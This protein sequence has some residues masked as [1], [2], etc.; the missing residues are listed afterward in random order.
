M[1]QS[2]P[3][4]RNQARVAPAAID[5]PL[6]HELTTCAALHHLSGRMSESGQNPPPALQK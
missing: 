5:I 6:F 1:G 3:R 2:D 4:G